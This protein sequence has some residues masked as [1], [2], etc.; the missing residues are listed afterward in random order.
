LT[1]GGDE[2]AWGLTPADA[3]ALAAAPLPSLKHLRL[4]RVRL[5]FMAACAE[6]AWL[7][8][9][10]RLRIG[11]EGGF[12][13]GGGGGGGGIPEG[14]SAWAAA[15]FTALVSLTLTYDYTIAPPSEVSGFVA[16]VAAP[17][18]GRLQELTVGALPLGSARNFDGD[19]DGA[20]LRALV[21]APLPNLTSLTLRGT[22]LSAMDV[23][24]ELPRAPWLTTLTRLELAYN[25]LDAPGHHALSLLH[26]PRLRALSLN[27]NALNPASLAAL[28]PAPWLTQLTNLY[29]AEEELESPQVY[30]RVV[31]AIEDDA[32][33]FGRLRRLGCTFDTEFN[34]NFCDWSPPIIDELGSDLGTDFGDGSDS[35]DG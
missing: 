33:A 2:S 25:D 14:S 12:L 1:G 9:L 5:G 34:D 8:R 10:Q 6:A 32:G 19:F 24:I 27:S 11:G 15:P 29:L 3:R 20:G 18:F 7:S 22:F 13:G 26:L 23:S 16:L 30:E 4:A 35:G 21:A 17:W 31:R 28:A